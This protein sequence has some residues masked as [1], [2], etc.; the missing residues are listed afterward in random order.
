M[1]QTTTS[2]DHGLKIGDRV[3]LIP[4]TLTWSAEMTLRGKTGEVIEQATLAQT[5]QRVTVRFDNGRLL[6]SRDAGLFER[7]SSSG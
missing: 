7:V 5:S 2:T 3:R 4:G 1:K 6:M